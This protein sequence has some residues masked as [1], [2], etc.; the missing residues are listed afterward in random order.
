MIKYD[1]II[2]MIFHEPSN[3]FMAVLIVVWSF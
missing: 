3:I 1:L 2:S